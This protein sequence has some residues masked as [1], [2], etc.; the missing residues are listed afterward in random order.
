MSNILDK[1]YLEKIRD[2]IVS[3]SKRAEIT[4]SGKIV[5]SIDF[6]VEK[7]GDFGVK[8]FIQIYEGEGDITNITSYDKEGNKI[9]NLDLEINE[10][11][12]KKLREG[13][14]AAF[15][16]FVSEQTREDGVSLIELEDIAN[17][18]N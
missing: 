14:I 16:F 15:Y 2:D 4:V 6:H 1:T 12:V 9:I 18:R 13:F 10:I 7:Y 8:V 17:E 5:D 11:D 3:R